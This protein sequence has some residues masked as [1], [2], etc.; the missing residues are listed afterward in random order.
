MR[1]KTFFATFLLF[2][3]VLYAGITAFSVYMTN[4][5]IQILKSGGG[6]QFQTITSSLSRDIAVLW[7][8]HI[9]QEM[10]YNALDLLVESYSRYYEGFGIGISLAIDEFYFEEEPAGLQTRVVSI[11]NEDGEYFVRITGA[12]NVPFNHLVVDYRQDISESMAGLQNIRRI[13][14]IFAFTSSVLAAFGLLFVLEVVFRPLTIVSNASRKIAGGEYSERIKIKG[15]NEL[16]IVAHDFNKMA[17]TIEDQMKFL[18]NEAISKQQYV[19]NFAHEIRTPL[20]T[21]YGYAQYLRVSKFNEDDV[22][23]SADY[24]MAEANHM[25]NMANSLLKLAT[26]RSFTPVK[27]KIVIHELLS[28]LQHS[29][30][31]LLIENKTKLSLQC[32]KG[33]VLFGQEDLIKSLLMNICI[34]GINATAFGE[35]YV[36][37]SAY[38]DLNDIIISVKDNGRGIPE[39]CMEKIFEPFYRIDKAR[40]REQ[41]G[42]GLGLTLCKQIV[43]AHGGEM[44]VVSTLGFG[45]TVEIKFENIKEM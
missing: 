23:E 15:K 28:D 37:L 20:T 22:F 21:I 44:I 14:L 30:E 6:A 17:Q 36:E 7:G 34:N 29:L 8:M 4:S 38:M 1:L 39:D 43:E 18:V 11:I 42:A 33:I 10:F 16:A 3:F 31:N 32:E 24:I 2:V 27:T 9:E 13:L 19:D 25:S 35:G 41:G 12:L 45:T 5:Q 26:L 40:S